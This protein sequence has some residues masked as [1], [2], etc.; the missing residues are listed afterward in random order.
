MIGDNS[1]QCLEYSIAKSARVRRL[2]LDITLERAINE[3]ETGQTK[4]MT[5][6]VSRLEA[7]YLTVRCTPK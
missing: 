1:G 3:A 4:P 6:V 5:E 2:V 7:K